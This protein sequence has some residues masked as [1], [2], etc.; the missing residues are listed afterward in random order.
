MT[1]AN[2]EVALGAKVRTPV[3]PSTHS[4]FRVK[5]PDMLDSYNI[6]KIAQNL[7]YL[8]C[9]EYHLPVMFAYMMNWGNI[10][11]LPLLRTAIKKDKEK[12][13]VDLF[14]D[15]HRDPQRASLVQR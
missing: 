5:G 7:A 9:N 2:A 1:A 4:N 14:I 10:I 13:P 11:P 15:V 3:A 6:Q 12:Y 8:L